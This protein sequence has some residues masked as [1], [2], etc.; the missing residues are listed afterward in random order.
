MASLGIDASLSC[1]ASALGSLTGDALASLSASVSGLP[2]DPLSALAG[3]AMATA[4]G[5]LG[6]ALG[7]DLLQFQS[8]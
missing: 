8:C 4:L 2:T 5:Q 1:A 3:M 7:V 6:E